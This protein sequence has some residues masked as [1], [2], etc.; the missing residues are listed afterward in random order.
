[1]LQNAQKKTRKK[2]T[3]KR[4]KKNAQKNAQKTHKKTHKKRTKKNAQKT[5]EK[6]KTQTITKHLWYLFGDNSLKNF[7]GII[8]LFG[9]K[10][11][12]FW[13]NFFHVLIFVN[14][15]YILN[16]L[17]KRSCDVQRAIK[18]CKPTLVCTGPFIIF[19]FKSFV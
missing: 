6:R 12:G 17:V 16:Y 8:K 5:Q 11:I 2:R 18:E 14:I 19:I 1:M 10:C 9:D 4:T 3:K 15:F 13:E 7:V